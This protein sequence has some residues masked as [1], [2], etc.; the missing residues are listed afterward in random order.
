MQDDKTDTTKGDDRTN[1][2]NNMLD[3][4][5]RDP[6]RISAMARILDVLS[7]S[8]TKACTVIQNT[9]RLWMSKRRTAACQIQ[10]ASRLWKFV[11]KR[12]HA[13]HLIAWAWRQ[14]SGKRMVYL[15][16]QKEN[17]A[18]LIQ[19]WHRSRIIKIG[20]AMLLMMKKFNASLGIHEIPKF[21]ESDQLPANNSTRNID[22]APKQAVIDSLWTLGETFGI[23]ASD[24]GAVN[25]SFE[26][27]HSGMCIRRQD[28]LTWLLDIIEDPC[29]EMDI[30]P[31]CLSLI[32][33][34]LWVQVDGESNPRNKIPLSEEFLE[35]LKNT[36]IA[37]L[38]SRHWGIFRGSMQAL[39]EL[40]NLV[41]L[42]LSKPV[43]KRL[44]S[45]LNHWYVT[46]SPV[47]QEYTHSFKT[48]ELFLNWGASIAWHTLRVIEGA[49][50]NMTWDEL[51]SCGYFRMVHLILSANCGP[52]RD[53]AA[54]VAANLWDE[55][56]CGEV[57]FQKALKAEVESWLKSSSLV[58][59]VMR[60][61]GVQFLLRGV[62]LVSTPLGAPGEKLMVILPGR[63]KD[64]L[65]FCNHVAKFITDI[66]VAGLSSPV[67]MSIA[68][69]G[70]RCKVGPGCF[71]RK[72]EWARRGA[73]N[74]T[75]CSG[76]FAGDSGSA[77]AS[78]IDDLALGE[79]LN[80]GRTKTCQ[81]VALYVLQGMSCEEILR[82][83]PLDAYSD[84][85]KLNSEA[86]HGAWFSRP[87]PTDSRLHVLFAH[88]AVTVDDT[89]CLIRC[90][91]DLKALVS[92]GQTLLHTAC[93]F[94]SVK[95][96]EFLL[97]KGF[98]P[99]D[100]N[101]DG[102]D[103][104][105][106]AK[107]FRHPPCV[108]LLASA[109]RKFE[110]SLDE[111]VVSIEGKA[112][113]QPTPSKSSKRKK[114]R[115]KGTSSK[116]DE[117]IMDN[118]ERQ[119]AIGDTTPYCQKDT[120]DINLNKPI[121]SEIYTIYE[122]ISKHDN[123]AQLEYDGQGETIRIA[124]VNGTI[125]DLLPSLYALPMRTRKDMCLHLLKGVDAFH[126]A[127]F[128]HY[129]VTPSNVFYRSLLDPG[130]YIIKVGPVDVRSSPPPDPSA[131]LFYPQRTWDRPTN[132]QSDLFAVGCIISM[133][134]CG[135]HIF[136]LEYKDQIVNW[137]EK[138]L[139]NSLLLQKESMEF[140]D[141]VRRMIK[142]SYNSTKDC[143]SHPVFWDGKR[144]FLYVSELFRMQRHQQLPPD[145][146]LGLGRDWRTILPRDGLLSRHLNAGIST[147]DRS[148]KE[149]LRLL[150]NF[151][152]HPPE[153]TKEP[154]S[155]ASE[156]LLACFPNLFPSLY[157]VF[158]EWD[159]VVG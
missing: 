64:D 118:N 21:D 130:H 39:M 23:Y 142:G 100:K 53:R 125:L 103:A 153:N 117:A 46:Q 96:C 6:C 132:P 56:P 32:Y 86:L 66:F 67:Y 101:S 157:F 13:V 92:E 150:R 62:E 80:R 8:S 97:E 104:L 128:V 110:I 75:T 88:C 136:G 48:K 36:C 112:V 24:A 61:Q 76:C 115:N 148:P 156:E 22:D 33:V 108:K 4:A 141:L 99:L 91:R 63:S 134:V 124:G 82:V 7:R 98:S 121:C 151:F 59:I 71:D 2:M 77:L 106:I 127:G 93:R 14:R 90:P 109:A 105:I 52:D 29:F 44:I 15:D 45:F 60:E 68:I 85:L 143:L 19:R 120:F 138:N 54:F 20:F 16:Q 42:D 131:G 1:V 41:D 51:Q 78:L 25:S 18:V 49:R 137:K 114:R 69:A 155:I 145:E 123:I 94:G 40:S 144:R 146:T 81:L 111:L 5:M 95:A 30:K 116:Q 102:D 28:V 74:Y 50:K 43:L 70:F 140:D 73:E 89:K 159:N 47:L 3:L 79:A 87:K 83:V 37:N 38:S 135:H 11:R 55:W 139:F 84:A 65:Q 27:Y 31:L 147:Y 119:K 57:R 12:E 9:V 10:R 152:Q 122:S 72:I 113:Q 149:L 35:R 34:S 154:L 26:F 126:S 107:R 17:A 58:N 158:G 133:V 129:N